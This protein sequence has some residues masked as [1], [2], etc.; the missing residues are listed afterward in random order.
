[1]DLVVWMGAL[2]MG[3]VSVDLIPVLV[4]CTRARKGDASWCIGTTRLHEWYFN[5]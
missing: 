3:K 4:R 5:T 2:C 1:M